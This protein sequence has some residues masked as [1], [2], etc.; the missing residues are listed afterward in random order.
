LLA[1][2]LLSDNVAFRHEVEQ[3]L[4]QLAS[5]HPESVLDGFGVALLDPH[6][7]WRL[8]IGVCRDLIGQLPVDSVLAWV[9]KHGIAGARAIARHLPLPHLDEAGDP[10]VPQ[11]LDRILREYDDD[12]VFGNFLA[13]ARSG[14]VWWGNGGDQFRLAAE[15][16]RKFLHSPNRRIREWANNE[17]K[18]RLH[19]AELEDQEH[20]ERVLPS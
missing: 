13:G 16:A 15:S 17:I 8:Q 10:I 18:Y 9:R 4:S 14:E 19:L 3:E 20:E 12:K 1:Q 11:V 2:G 6:H 5:V 7:G